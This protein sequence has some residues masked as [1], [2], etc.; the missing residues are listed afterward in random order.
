MQKFGFIHEKLDIKILILFILRRLP[1]AVDHDTLWDLVQCDE[2]VVYFYF[3]ECLA[4]L[5]DTAHI[6]YEDKK[7]KITEKGARNAETVES[8]LPYSVRMKAERMLAPLA[9]KMRRDAMIITEH[10]K[11]DSGL[12][13]HLAMS[14]GAGEIIDM[15]L[16]IASENQAKIIE[17]NFRRDAEKIYQQIIELVSKEEDKEEAK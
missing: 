15:R 3:A 9:D 5:V 12:I 8:S 4:D 6:D 7:Y 11:T 1:G 2:G 10:F 13:E 14:D 17:T 16:L